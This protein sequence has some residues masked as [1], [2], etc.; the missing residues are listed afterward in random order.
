MSTYEIVA[1]NTATASENAMH[2]DD[3]AQRYG[4]RGGLVPGVDVYAYLTHPPAARWGLDW[5]RQGRMRGRFLKPVYDGDRVTVLADEMGD[6]SL[7][8]EVRDNSGQLCAV[9]SA[10]L[11][12]AAP[13]PPDPDAWAVVEQPHPDARPDPTPDV[14]AAGTALGM[15]P[16]T[17]VADRAGE[18]LDEVRET[19]PLYAAARVAHPGW[20]LRDANFVLARSVR[21]GPWIHV[22]S[23]AQHLD[24]VGDGELVSCRAVVTRE[25]E[26]KGHRFVELDV[27]H[28]AGERP[29]MRVTHT[30]IHTPR[31]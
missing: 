14:L 6:G 18:Y 29:V 31:R 26:H 15:T 1:H 17:F 25:W 5:L 28:L 16:H 4:F 20:L 10:S 12:A 7:A 2:H 23:D 24:L 21:L 9:G 22:E 11:T 3:V 19:L 13:E 27:L 8:L 30:A